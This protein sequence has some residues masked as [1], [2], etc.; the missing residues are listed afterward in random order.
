M[1][2]QLDEIDASREIDAIE[3]HLLAKIEKMSIKC[4]TNDMLNQLIEN[5]TII[6][7][8]LINEMR[9]NRE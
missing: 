5:Q 9:Y 3:N 8:V 4:K 1:I 6:M 7:K 2:S